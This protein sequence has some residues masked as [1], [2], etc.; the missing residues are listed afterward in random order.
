MELD[1]IYY[2]DRVNNLNRLVVLILDYQDI[3]FV[4]HVKFMNEKKYA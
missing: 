4:P 1:N 2:F 3:D